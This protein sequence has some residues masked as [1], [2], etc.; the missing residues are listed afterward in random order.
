MKRGIIPLVLI[1]LISLASAEI[2]INQQPKEIYNLGDTITLPVKI[3]SL[4]KMNNLF[5]M[6][7]ICNGIETEVYKEYIFLSA[8]EEKKR[9]PSIPLIKSFIGRTT[10]TCKIKTM[11]GEE[12]QLTN[13]FYIFDSIKVEIKTEKTEF[14]PEEEIAIEIEAIK[15]NNELVKGLVEAKVEGNFSEQI[16]FLDT[17]NNGYAYITFKMP[18]ETKAGDYIVKINVTEKDFQGE[19]TNT[20]FAEHAITILQVP[21]NLELSIENPEVEP[22]TSLKAKTTLYDQTGEKIPSTAVITIRDNKGVVLEKIEKQTEEFLEFP[23]AKNEPPSEEWSIK[24]ESN[25]FSA[26]EGI[27]IKERK[28][29]KTN[30]INRTLTVT[31][32]GNVL[33]NNTMLVKIGEESVEI[34]LS[35]GIGEEKK[36]TLT[37]PDGEYEVRIIGPEGES[38]TTAN[39]ILT[40]KAI[41]IKEA[42]TGIAG[43]VRYPI[44]W[45]FI[46]L[47]MGFV[48]FMLVKKGYKRSFFGYIN[49]KKNNLKKTQKKDSLITTNSPAEISLSLKGNKQNV[50]I[51][52]LR[53]K[54]FNDIKSD[55]ESAK[56]TL[57]KIVKIAEENKASIYV[58]QENIFFIFAPVKT[59]TFSNEKTAIKIAQAI[60][61]IITNHNKLFKQQI[62][63]GISLNY[64]A[65]VA[66]QEGSVLK[67][68]SMGTLITTAKKVSSISKGEILLGEKMKEKTAANVKTEKKDEGGM[69]YYKVKEIKNTEEHKKFIKSFLDRLEGKN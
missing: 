4:V 38:Q 52:A 22:G 47:I 9:E 66:K 12:S 7:L 16:E 39:V 69:A 57:Q 67:F 44:V 17:V 40:G 20:G 51:I 55:K 6:N 54:N 59:K 64:G 15:E 62:D 68:M 50:S 8:G 46:T 13:E 32:T 37:A 14:K 10:G 31:N 26:E 11:L 53:L 60:Q 30:I 58:N 23:I 41:E 45:I 3:T 25:G 48:T 56:E 65:I 61:Q 19:I 2:I 24:A 27:I 29:I 28:E 42:G 5:T 43:I 34:N 36:F 33:Y 21:T 1:L 49:S 63:F 18:K 35:L